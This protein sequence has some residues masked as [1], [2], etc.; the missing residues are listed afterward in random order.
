MGEVRVLAL[1]NHIRAASIRAANLLRLINNYDALFLNYPRDMEDGV[2]AL[3]EGAPYEQFVSWLREK[4]SVQE[5]L[6]S[7]EYCARPLLEALRGILLRR[8]DL[9]IYCYRDLSLHRLSMELAVKTA[10]LTLRACL[11]GR[12]QLDEWEGLLT[13]FL[14]SSRNA[15]GREIRLIQSRLE[16]HRRAICISDLSGRYIAD[17]LRMRGHR[18][19]LTY[20]YLP[21]HFTPLEILMNELYRAWVRGS[22]LPKG[23]VR[24]LLRHHLRFVR[25]YVVP[26]NSYD[27]A[28]QR[29]VAENAPWILR[30]SKGGDSKPA[31]PTS[32]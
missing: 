3:A 11:T 12:V 18:V 4:G 2:R 29:W 17:Q 26:S 8:P 19:H 1:P 31:R 22:R 27:E 15:L 24:E 21:Y 6:G 13:S 9:S 20:P 28:Y 16:E 5:P 32:P 23:R 14:E 10:L 25:D 30:P 7:W